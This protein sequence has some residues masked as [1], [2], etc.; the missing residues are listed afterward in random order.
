M[1]QV[2][3]HKVSKELVIIF[4]ECNSRALGSHTLQA[5][6][7]DY[8]GYLIKENSLNIYY[9]RVQPYNLASKYRKRLKY[10]AIG[11]KVK[12]L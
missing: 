5:M 1:L 4:R 2:Y 8:K 9:T 10:I 6:D 7:F 12:S 3:Q 11:Y